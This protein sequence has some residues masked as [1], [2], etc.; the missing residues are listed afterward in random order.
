MRRT[1]GCG[2]WKRAIDRGSRQ[3]ASK[4]KAF[5]LKL[6]VNT[7]RAMAGRNVESA[8]RRQGD[9]RGH[10]A[11]RP[12]LCK[13]RLRPQLQPEA[14]YVRWP[15]D[16]CWLRVSFVFAEFLFENRWPLLGNFCLA[17]AAG[18]ASGRHHRRLGRQLQSAPA[19][20]SA[21][22]QA[23][24]PGGFGWEWPDVQAIGP[25]RRGGGALREGTGA[26][27][28]Q[29]SRFQRELIC[30]NKLGDWERK[31]ALA[32]PRH[33]AYRGKE[34]HRFP[35]RP[36]LATGLIRP[37]HSN[38]DARSISPPT[39]FTRSRSRSGPAKGGAMTSC[40]SPIFRR[41]STITPPLI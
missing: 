12:T 28:G 2:K 24:L 23:R 22:A 19:S 1:I 37:L 31:T 10:A 35:L 34:A 36:S 18:T 7:A 21:G 16:E 5:S 38:A 3:G 11:H 40:G 29:L 9:G 32:G 26:G 6:C 13:M 41:T 27:A 20:R 17:A 14:E 8:A 33:P 30:A 25:L 39:H 4:R 15:P